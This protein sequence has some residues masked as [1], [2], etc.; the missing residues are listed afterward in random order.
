[1]LLCVA[2]RG[3]EHRGV[4]EMARHD[5]QADR[6]AGAAEA[7]RQRGRRMARQVE[8]RGVGRPQRV[9]L[10]FRPVGHVL[11]HLEGL[12]RHGGR[13]QEVV[14]LEEQVPGHRHLAPAGMRGHDV[15]H[16]VAAARLGARQQVGIELAV[17]R[18]GIEVEQALQ[19]AE[20]VRHEDAA[21]IGVRE[22]RRRRSPRLC[23]PSCRSAWRPWSPAPPPRY[24]A[25]ARTCA[26][27]RRRAAS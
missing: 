22:R 20:P 27:G 21:G 13:Q 2:R 10:A 18:L 24:R 5:L 6:Q 23:S 4:L 8:G 26:A 7:T 1:M 25:D 12:H 9:G 17:P 15:V 19:V 3:G 16:G 14:F 11:Q